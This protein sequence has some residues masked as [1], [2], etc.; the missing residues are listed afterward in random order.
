MLGRH[1]RERGS[2]I[3]IWNSGGLL[4]VLVVLGMFLLL[5]N[6]AYQGRTWNGRLRRILDYYLST[7]AGAIFIFMIAMLVRW[8]VA[9]FV[10]V[11]S[12]GKAAPA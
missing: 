10:A 9:P 4:V 3:F 5:E 12:K 2:V 1:G 7:I 6:W 8:Y 11:L